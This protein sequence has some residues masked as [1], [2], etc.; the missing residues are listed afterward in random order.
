MRKP[1]V[2]LLLA[3]TALFLAG[4]GIE[5]ARSAPPVL[6]LAVSPSAFSPNADSVKD[7]VHISVR[8]GQPGT[9]TVVVRGPEG[10]KV[11]IPAFQKPVG[12]GPVHFLWHGGAD[13]DGRGPSV[14]D[15]SYLVRA[16]T[17]DEAGARVVQSTKVRLDTTPPRIAWRKRVPA[18]LLGSPLRLGFRVRDG[19]TEVHVGFSLVDQAG[20]SIGQEGRFLE[21]TG[22]GALS[23]P[24]THRLLSPGAYRLALTATD[25]V[26]NSSTSSARP[27]LV[28]HAVR[29]HTWG[30]FSGVGRHVA[31]T[32]DDCNFPGAWASILNTL[33]RLKLKASFFCPGRQVLA[34]PA[35]ARRTVRDGHTIGSHGWDHAY[36][37]GLSYGGAL[38]RLLDDRDV[39]WRLARAAPTPYFRPPYGAYNASTV[40]AAGSAGYAAT[41]LWDV[42]PRD[43]SQPGSTAIVQRVVSA[44]QPGSIVLMHVMYQTAAALPTIIHDL[45]ARKLQ[46]ISLAEMA[47]IGTPGPGHW[48]SY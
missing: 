28:E 24:R 31:L 30:R 15:G 46:P 45:Q 12:R 48:P 16:E 43:W 7:A 3:A 9:L 26:G 44:T 17:V 2:A 40:A 23:W 41:V 38:Q 47:R 14:R 5:T 13:A 42:D 36:F 8:V 32:F 25:D 20:A 27:V 19:S 18:R 29:A 35:L 34:A 11:F 22:S 4:S 1:A 33:R 37:P 6:Q 39:W 10:R 21:S